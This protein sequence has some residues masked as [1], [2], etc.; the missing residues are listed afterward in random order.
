MKIQSLQY[1]VTLAETGSITRAAQ[2]LY[3][4]QPSLTKSL[5][6]MEEELGFTLV[7][8]SAS[9]VRL[10]EKGSRVFAEARQI[11]EFYDG[12][13]EMGRKDD[14]RQIELY[15]YISFP[16]FLLPDIV[17]RYRKKYPELSIGFN[18]SEKPE[19]FISRSANKPV[20]SLVMCHQN[21]QLAR[22]TQIQGNPPVLLMSG[23]YRCLVNAR[24]ALAS[25]SSVTLEELKNFYLILPDM[26][27]EERASEMPEGFLDGLLCQ[28][29]EQK[30]VG[31]ET[32]ANVIPL[33]EKDDESYAL[34][35]WPA[36]K[37][38][39]GVQEGRLVC[40]P[41]A[42]ECAR[43]QFMLCYSRQAYDRYPVVRQLVEDIRAAARTFLRQN[44][45]AEP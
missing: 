42:D 28:S 38:Y 20:L 34:S 21:E 29:P 37:R 41:I 32:V 44:P 18:V 33:V 6:L 40:V 19:A 23:E 30:K 2:Q 13:K 7:E 24:H 4:A 25:H 5:K 31:V 35:F 12:W 43:G 3:V 27:E 45:A 15:T 10:T 9:G 17:L 16:D 11:L 22:L 39:K 8:R 26:K 14:L 1:F 36:A